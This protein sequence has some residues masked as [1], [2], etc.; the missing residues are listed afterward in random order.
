[1]VIPRTPIQA[2]GLLLAAVR[3]PSP[4]LVLEPKIL[5]VSLS[6]LAPSAMLTTGIAQP[7]SGLLRTGRCRTEP[8]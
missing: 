1:M 4:T 6:L 7:V 8:H 3:D 5:W 2:K